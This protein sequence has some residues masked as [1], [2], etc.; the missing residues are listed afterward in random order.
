M[1]ESELFALLEH[2][3]DVAYTVTDAGEI[4]SWNSAAEHLFGYTAQEVLQ[5]NIDE[6]LDARDTLGTP[7]LAELHAVSHP[8]K[9]GCFILEVPAGQS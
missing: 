2:T 3:A 4:C 9:G 7:A 8:G 1:L 5:R 6:V